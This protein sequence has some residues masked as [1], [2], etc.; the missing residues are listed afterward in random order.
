MTV[1]L[2]LVA[3]GVGSSFVA[4]LTG[5]LHCGLMCGPLACAGAQAGKSRLGAVAWHVG[6]IGAYAG[7]GA[8]L[9]ALGGS[10]ASALSVSAQRVLP[11][12]MAVGLVATALDLGKHLR[13][14]PGVG[15]IS[16]VLARL[17]ARLGPLGRA[18]A[19]G[20][21]TPFLP[22]GLLYGLFLAA[23]A[24]SSA[25][26]G[27]LVLAAFSLGGAPA[28]A[29]AQVGHGTLRARWPQLEPIVR[30]VVPLTAAA[31]LIVRALQATDP[32]CP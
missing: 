27:A 15:A 10:V 21:A 13:P 22:C 8:V 2:P 25:L 31:I 3:A 9:G 7:V 5:S 32:A 28:L 24:T 12:V 18:L 16:R 26:G 30:R 17:G 23:L 11:F 14:L 1:V 19:L 29:A 20:A 4:G 6:R